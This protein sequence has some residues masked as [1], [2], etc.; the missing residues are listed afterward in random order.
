MD[1]YYTLS[2]EKVMNGLNTSLSGLSDE[3]AKLRLGQHGMNELREAKK[4]SPIVIFLAQFNNFLVW[5]LLIAVG[6]SAAIG[7]VVESIVITIIIILNA[8]IG[9]LQEYRAEKAIE[10]LKKLA[11]LRTDV[12]RNGERKQVDA[13]ELVPGDIIIIETGDKISADCRLIEESNLETQESSLTGESTPVRKGIEAVRQSP[14]AERLNTVFSGTIVTKGRAKAVVVSTGMRTEIGRIATLI[15]TAK[16]ELTPLQKK[17]AGFGKQIGIMTIVIAAIVFGAT[18]LRGED[19]LKMFEVAVSLAVAAIPEGL[20]AVVAMSLALGVQRMIKRNALIRKLPSVETLGSTTV[21]ATDKTGT[22]TLDKMTVKK[23]YVGGK[24]TEVAGEGYSTSERLSAGED[25]QLLLRIG[26]ICNDSALSG[27]SISGDPTEAALLVSAAKAGIIKESLDSKFRRVDE[28]PFDSDRK[29]MTTINEAGSQTVMY[30]KGAPDVVLRLCDR[31]YINGKIKEMAP[32]DLRNA[33]KANEQ[34]ASEALRV[35]GLAYKPVKN[36]A[37]KSEKNLIFV[38]L[39][40]M[41]DPPR[42]EVKAAIDKCRQ[43]GISVV[44]ITGDHKL[45]AVAIA[46]ELGIE[47]KAVT[48]KELDLISNLG[49]KVDEIGVYARVSPEHKIKIIDAL[50]KKGHIAAMTGDGVND[51][52]ALKKADI[53]IAMGITGTDVSKEASKMILTDDNFASIVNAVEEGR[54]VYEN[55][56]KF[57][58]SLFSSNL[59]EV[60]IIFLAII[61]GLELPLL[62]IQILWLNL[63]TDGLPAIALGFEP[64]SKELMTK[65][66]RRKDENILNK[67][68]VIRLLVNAIFVT[69]GTLGL[70]IWALLRGGWTWGQQLP[71]DSPVYIYAIT[72][73][74]TSLLFFEMFTALTAKSSEKNIFKIPL[75]DNKFLLFAIGLSLFLILAVVYTPLSTYFSTVPLLPADLALIVL[76]TSTVFIVDMIHKFFANRQFNKQ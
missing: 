63:L 45:T 26:A 4:I 3:E 8:V 12:I 33:E 41:I 22:L 47:G 1:D 56:K 29:R 67:P 73:A 11:G 9:F 24:V 39:Q 18:V 23:L 71:N 7:D 6:I 44:M 2:A 74:F 55:I 59:A 40:A 53:G 51:A 13:K 20:P 60:L 62:A 21:I 49:E 75:L 70:Y 36:A 35:L 68:I 42:P 43:A 65:K 14:I 76:A 66:P 48:G 72:V 46:K 37:D 19:P 54:G 16:E 61:L 15:E 34:F 50:K 10:A 38:G 28:I 30:T 31:I 69:A 32:T 52:P 27:E 25:E 58:Y 64:I 57:I 17:L 5:I